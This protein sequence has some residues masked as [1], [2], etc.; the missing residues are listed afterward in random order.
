MVSWI[1][2]VSPMTVSGD[3]GLSKLYKC[4]LYTPK[5]YIPRREW[6]PTGFWGT[7]GYIYTII[8]FH[9]LYI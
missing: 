3:L 4:I 2:W 5:K 8:Y 1:P 9:I 6:T 7:H